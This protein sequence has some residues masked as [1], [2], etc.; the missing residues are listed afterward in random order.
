M[1]FNLL[2]SAAAFAALGLA[3][4]LG[5][6]AIAG[7]DNVKFPQELGQLYGS[8][9]RADLKFYR[10]FYAHPPAAAEAAREGKPLPS[11]T[12]LTMVSYKAKLDDKGEPVKDTTG[13]FVKGD[14]AAY[15]VMEKRTGWG[16]EY[17]PEL[18][19]GEWEY[20]AFT[21]A[22]AVNEKANIKG[23]FE[24]HKPKETIDYVFTFDRLKAT[25]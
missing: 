22:K 6:S 17:A 20:Q 2:R 19:N 21:A 10:E 23:C 15:A 13:R 3:A 18:R 14:I 8:L 12:V 24:C 7:P 5:V 11:G 9:D 16:A 25:R 4:T 1:T